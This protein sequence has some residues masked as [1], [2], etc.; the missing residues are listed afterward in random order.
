MC[1]DKSYYI[2]NAWFL[3]LPFQTAGER[4]CSLWPWAGAVLAGGLCPLDVAIVKHVQQKGQLDQ[5]PSLKQSE[6]YISA[7]DFLPFLCN[8]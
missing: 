3:S 5:E 8:I 6:G 4:K 7:A 1:L 2:K